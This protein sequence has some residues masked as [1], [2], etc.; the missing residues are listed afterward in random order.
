MTVAEAE[1]GE[2]TKEETGA[3]P[4]DEAGEDSGV[5]GQ[6]RITTTTTIIYLK[7][8]L[9]TMGGWEAVQRTV[10]VRAVNSGAVKWSESRVVLD[11]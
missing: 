5:R 4:G 10:R 3:V 7:H 11:S 8:I 1:P 9:T 2:E 6:G